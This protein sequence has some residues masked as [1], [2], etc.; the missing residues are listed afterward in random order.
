MAEVAVVEIV[1]FAIAG[2]ITIFVG[3]RWV[4]LVGVLA[5]FALGLFFAIAEAADGESA[6]IDFSAGEMFG[7]GMIAGTIP[8]PGWAAGVLAVTAAR[9]L[10]T[11]RVERRPIH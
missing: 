3:G 2:A 11:H 7:I 9:A 1:A 10:I 8:L 5:P 6:Y 4:L